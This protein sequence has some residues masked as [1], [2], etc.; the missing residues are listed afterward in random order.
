[1]VARDRVGRAAA[2]AQGAQ[3]RGWLEAQRGL[4]CCP[5]YGRGSFLALAEA[6]VE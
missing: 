1:M 6:P 3:S 5:H 4:V 2:K